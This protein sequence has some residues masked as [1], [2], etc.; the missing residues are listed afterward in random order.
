VNCLKNVPVQAIMDVQ[1]E[2]RDIFRNPITL[3]TPCVE[4]ENDQHTFLSLHP[5]EVVKSG[6]FNKVPIIIGYNSHEG[7]LSMPDIFK[8]ESRMKRFDQEFED[9]VPPFMFYKTLGPEAHP[10]MKEIKDFYFGK[11]KKIEDDPE[12]FQHY[13][14]FLTDWV[15]G[16]GCQES[17]RHHAKHSP[18]Y[19]YFYKYKGE[20]QLGKVLMT[21]SGEPYPAIA[22]MWSALKEAFSKHVLRQE[23][24]HHGAGHGDELGI[25]FKMPRVSDIR[26]G[27]QDYH[28]GKDLIKLWVSIAK[29]ESPLRF[30]NQVWN[31]VEAKSTSLSFL[32]LDSEPNIIN[33]PHTDR[34]KFMSK[35]HPQ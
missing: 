7:L 30:K 27:H 25:Q 1:M 34:I 20:F 2:A 8:H 13:V 28:F 24:I 35:F 29:E 23:P 12:K 17:V 9:V 14:G 15:W 33:D 18:T 22:F 6:N 10:D 16:V 3:F 32:L 31:P 5:R 21:I 19:A 4:A 11:N 26:A